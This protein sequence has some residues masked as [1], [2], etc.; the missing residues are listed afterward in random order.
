[1]LHFYVR[2]TIIYS[3]CRRKIT[4]DHYEIKCRETKKL[5]Y[6]DE[7][8]QKYLYAAYGARQIF[9][10]NDIPDM[11]ACVFPSESPKE[12]VADRNISSGLWF[13]D[14]AMLSDEVIL[15]KSF[16]SGKNVVIQYLLSEEELSRDALDRK[17]EPFIK[18]F[19]KQVET[20][21]NIYGKFSLL[22]E[23]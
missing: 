8:S 12:Q 19:D 3:A 14:G 16:A 20:T 18:W 9:R 7:K 10:K 13:N 1:M 11:Q 6:I 23:S 21:I 22:E 4:D 2:K 15:P 5:F 17:F